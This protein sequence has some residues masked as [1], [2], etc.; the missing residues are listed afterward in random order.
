MPDQ[1]SRRST[2][3]RAR[4]RG[5]WTALKLTFLRRTRG[6]VFVTKEYP[7]G[8]WRRNALDGDYTIHWDLDEEGF[9]TGPSTDDVDEAIAWGRKRAPLVLVRVGPTEDDFYSA[10][11]R[12][13]TRELPELGGTDLTPYPEWPPSWWPGAQDD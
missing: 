7:R 1:T 5:R 9:V 2:L 4:R 8:D 10:G 11:E 12:V 6:I 13:A 3:E